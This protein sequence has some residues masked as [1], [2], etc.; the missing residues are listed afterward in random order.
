MSKF[1]PLRD[2]DMSLGDSAE[3]AGESAKAGEIKGLT[4]IFRSTKSSGL[5]VLTVVRVA[6]TEFVSY[7]SV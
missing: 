1:S 3:N 6:L 5:G 2:T 7:P 4:P